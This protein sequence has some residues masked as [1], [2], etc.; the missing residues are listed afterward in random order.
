MPVPGQDD[1]VWGNVLNGFLGVSHNA[2]GT[3]TQDAVS[4]AGAYIKPG[5]GIPSTDL[6]SST[7]SSLSLA[8]SSVQLGGDLGGTTTTP[9]V[10]A[11][12]GVTVSGTPAAGQGILATGSTTAQWTRREFN[13]MAFGAKGDGTTDDTTAINTCLTAA[14][15][16]NGEVYFP[17]ASG[18]CYRTTGV[19]VPGNVSRIFGSADLY[20]AG[21]TS[22]AYLKG[23]VL[24][25]LNSSVTALMTIGTNGNGTVVNSNP[26]GLR[27]EGIGFLGTLSGG[28]TVQGLW[29]A[30]VT[31]TSDVTFA[32][33]RDL[34]CDPRSATGAGGFVQFLSS[35]SG[36]GFSENGR[37]LFCASYNSGTFLYVDGLSTGAGGS[38]DGRVIGCQ[39]NSHYHGL[40]FGPV[41]AGTGGWA[42]LETHFSS[43]NAANHIYYGNAGTPWTLRVESCYFDVVN[44][45]HI[46]ANTGRGL[47]VIGNYFRGGTTTTIAINFGAGLS[48]T[49]RD[50]AALIVGN[51]FDL[52]KSTTVTAFTRFQGFT[53]A[54]FAT[55]GGGEYR[56][57]LIHNHG[58]AMPGSWVAPFIGSDNLAISSTTTATLELSAGATLSA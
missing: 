56:S 58:S 31:D 16:V 39:L 15:A 57:N 47:Q 36:N 49:G 11:I 8:N 24:G 45:N 10:T 29:G 18:G 48:T 23:S 28:S 44:T 53:A 3:L 37:L 51:T 9:R 55:N 52:N 21:G 50:P 32:Y 35:A 1:G 2:D 14:A 30:I 6:S 22:V 42:V 34:S 4:S 54:N 43:T 38:T 26:H 20:R 27:V 25:P 41:N 46:L 17:P 19:T 33:C 12:N 40:Q 5:T 7:Q 13:V